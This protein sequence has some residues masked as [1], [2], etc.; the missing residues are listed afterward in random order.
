MHRLPILADFLFLHNLLSEKSIDHQ[1]FEATSSHV[2]KKFN[3]N[4]FLSVGNL[5]TLLIKNNDLPETTNRLVAYYILY[6]IF[7]SDS[8]PDASPKESPFQY[9]L[10]SLIDSKD[11]YK[12]NTVERNFIMQL[13]S[14]GTK[15]VSSLITLR[16]HFTDAL[17]SAFKTNS[18]SH[19]AN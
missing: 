19:Q 5:L 8:E 4:D 16:R 2:Q 17:I 14:S 6:D 13:L 1:S 18:P 3:R 9:F 11:T 10:L 15:D 12:L 7:K